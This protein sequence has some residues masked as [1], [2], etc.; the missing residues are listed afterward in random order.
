MP[1]EI[2]RFEQA[3]VQTRQQIT[4]VQRRVV[5]NMSA[6]EADI[7]DAHLLMLEDR[8]LIDEV[9]RLIREQKVNADFAFHTVVRA[10]CRRAGRRG[11]RISPR[12]RRRHARPDRARAGQ[13]A[14]GQGR[15]STSA[16]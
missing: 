1:E 11:G 7:F 4:E 6:T 2:K 14:R 16:I 3:L 9:I 10:L 12:T 5:D 13:S 15:S 8:V